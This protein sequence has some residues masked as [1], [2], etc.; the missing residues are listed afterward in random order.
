MAGLRKNKK[1]TQILVKGI[2]GNYES[3]L[4]IDVNTSENHSRTA[5][6]TNN[7]IENGSIIAD[8][9]VVN[10]QSFTINGIV[11]NSPLKLKNSLASSVGGAAS[12]ELGGIAG[13]LISYAT[14]EAL[15]GSENGLSLAE[16]AFIQLETI[17]EQAI[18]VKVRNNFY[19]YED[20]I[21]TDIQVPRDQSTG[22]SLRFTAKFEKIKTVV[23]KTVDIVATR[24]DTAKAKQSRGR[25]NSIDVEN[26]SKIEQGQSIL[27]RI[28]S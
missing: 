6:V 14:S 22:E 16:L 3:I 13:G 8:H 26:E 27:K 10:P 21:I 9:V 2:D 28:F 24:K 20:M 15:S 18:P 5:I 1:M 12:N 7:E 19:I 25:Q 17:Q 11:T 23:S 4:T